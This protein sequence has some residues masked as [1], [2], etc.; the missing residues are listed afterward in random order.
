[1]I[2]AAQAI[3][4]EVDLPQVIGRLASLVLENAGAQ[5]GALILSRDGELVLSAVF[6]EAST[7]VEEGHGRP[8]SEA[9]NIP[10]SIVLYVARTTNP[11]VLDDS[12]AVTRFAED[13]YIK[14]G[15]PKSILCL[16]LLHQSRVS[17]ILYLE[18]RA[19]AGVFDAAR[20]ELLALLSAQAAIAI[21]NARLISNAKA[22]NREVKLANERL[23]IEVAHR[24]EELGRANRDLVAAKERLERELERREQMERER[25]QLQEQVIQGQR[26]R[27]VE[28]STP[29]IPIT[30][31]I[32]VMPLIETVD[33]ERAQQVLSAAL[34]GVQRHRAQVLILDITGIKHIDT[35]VAG[36]LLGVAGALRLLGAEAV[37]TG[38]AP[39]IATTLVGL[40]IDLASFVT[41]GTLQSGMDYALRRVRGLG[42]SQG[43]R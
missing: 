8:I 3:A 12:G 38:I 33:Q 10:E 20:V 19:I 25:T 35:N 36:T 26:A 6:G 21:E 1:V 14:K 30:D 43:H 42:L 9:D 34:E 4:S 41:K 15:A 13:A 7:A 24:T 28:M 23:E 17:G 37:L 31:E 40:G 29:V 18:N 32:L 39:E 5:R 27:L 2:R 16:P 11:L 22:A